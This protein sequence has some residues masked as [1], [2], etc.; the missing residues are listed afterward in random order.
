MSAARWLGLV[1]LLAAASLVA[2]AVGT[3]SIPISA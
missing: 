2:V 3:V 1:I